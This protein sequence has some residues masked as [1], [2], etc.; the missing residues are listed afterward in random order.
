MAVALIL[1]ASDTFSTAME[2]II[3]IW[4]SFF[5]ETFWSFFPK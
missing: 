5:A 2:A 1:L 4:V 3:E